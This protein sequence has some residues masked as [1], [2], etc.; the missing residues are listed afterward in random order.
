MPCSSG[1]ERERAAPLTTL[2]AA[3]VNSGSRALKSTAM[4]WR[5]YLGQKA[6]P[7]ALALALLYLTVMSLGLLMTAYLKWH[8]MS[9]ATLSLA[10]GLGAASG[11]A[12]TFVFPV[13]H[14]RTGKA[15]I[16]VLT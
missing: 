14:S 12:A 10:R 9:E 5:L 2:G 16:A 13:L 6:L 15:L 8:G 7:A 11:I 4:A 3:R 1:K